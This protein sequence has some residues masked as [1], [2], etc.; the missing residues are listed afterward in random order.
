MDKD[1]PSV[2]FSEGLG[3]NEGSH[4]CKALLEVHPQPL[5]MAC[6]KRGKKGT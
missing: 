2:F 5:E 6:T 1:L 3:L 4:T